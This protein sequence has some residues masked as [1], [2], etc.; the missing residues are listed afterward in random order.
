MAASGTSSDDLLVLR[1]ELDTVRARFKKLTT[2]HVNSE[3]DRELI[4]SL[5][6]GWFRSVRP[7]LLARGIA[8]DH[9]LATDML[10]Q[11]LLRL[12]GGRSLRTNYNSAL[13]KVRSELNELEV[14]VE[15]AYSAIPRTRVVPAHSAIEELILE[16]LDALVPSAAQSYRQALADI[17]DPERL[18]FRGTANELRSVLWDV[19]DR[20]APDHEV[21][22]SENFK[23]ESGLSKPTQKQK[24]RFILTS[25]RLP[26]NARKAPEATVE[27]LE[28]RVATLT[29]ETYNRSS[30]STH[31]ESARAEVKT[32]KGYLDSLLAE[33]L[34]IHLR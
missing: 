30:I 12:A 24:T 15:V 28:D 11:S 8:E 5:V 2:V 22:S 23:L 26:G 25:R 29:R 19:L 34:A 32:I 1:G 9:V 14:Q 16:T 21:M 3:S 33:L 27:L 6:Q 13:A 7:Q 4:R 10:M 31:Q 18:S 20:L 17:S